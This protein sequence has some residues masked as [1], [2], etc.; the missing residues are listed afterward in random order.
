M[1]KIFALFLCAFLI[2]A[3]PI[4]AYAE[5]ESSE[6]VEQETTVSENLPTE[7]E[8]ATES[9]IPADTETLPDQI[10]GFIK[11]NFEGTSFISLAITVIV[12]IFYEVKKHKSLNGSIGILN[13]NA[14]T[15]AENSAKAI[16]DVISRAD[17][18]VDDV[19]AKAGTIAD[20]SSSV[21]QNVLAE[22]KGYKEQ[23]EAMLSEIRKNAEEKQSLE[24][25]LMSVQK[26]VDTSK[27]ASKELADEI[28]ELL[29]LANIPNAKKEELYSRHRAA[30]DAI[31]T[32]EK[33]EV[34][35]N[36]RIEA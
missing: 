25:L 28:A 29:V 26:T 35:T 13:N 33:T 12:Y 14:V 16:S 20:N 31:E 8:V 22:V 24:A 36:D 5:G 18:I 10:V 19:L 27:L 6:P 1:K 23:M 11:E 9:E 17:N 15:V 21:I 32:A 3:T 34:V 4:I 30:V 2:C 7:E